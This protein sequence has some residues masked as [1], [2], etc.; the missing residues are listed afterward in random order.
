MNRGA[1]A[2]NPKNERIKK[3][4]FRFQKHACG[5]ADGTI[6][7]I[8]KAITRYESYTCFK[9]FTTFKKEQAIGFKKH[10]AK[11]PT[12]RRRGTIAISTMVATINDLK[13][14]FRWLSWQRGYKSQ[15][16]PTDV[17]YLNLS[18]NERRSVR[19]PAFRPAPTLEQIHA[20]IAAMPAA[21]EIEK[22]DRALLAMA[23]LTGARDS[24][25]T[26]LRLKH[27]DVERRLVMQDP[28]EVRTKRRKRIDTFF[29]PLGED[30]EAI[31]LGW[32]HYLR[33]EKLFG[34]DD[35]VFPRTC[36]K[37]DGQGSFFAEGVEPV[38]WENTQPIRRIFRDAF[39]AAGLPYFPP[40]SFRHTL[41][42]YAERHAPSIE[43]F[44]AFSQNLGHEQVSTTLMSYGGIERHR[45]GEL[46]RS[47]AWSRDK[48]RNDPRTRALFD[49]LLRLVDT[50][51]DDSY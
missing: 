40:H 7:A 51:R 14:F 22:R 31:V 29:V 13:E 32:L 49:E 18:D 27:V 50:R 15:I 44:K 5:K 16:N 47:A 42:K 26:S 36:V 8:R 1:P 9:D 4:Y 35:P 43:H 24:A 34:E 10:L 20:V 11:T 19:E 17:E 46:V 3:E 25:L 28:R 39:S 33:T 21:T 23:I 41:V 37:A 2:F 48:D 38:C 45:Q 12:A 30:L 6:D